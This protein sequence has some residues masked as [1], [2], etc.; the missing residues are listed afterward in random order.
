MK[1]VEAV[2]MLVNE[3]IDKLRQELVDEP[4]LSRAKEQIKGNLLLGL[5]STCNRMSRLAKMELFKDT[6]STPEETVARIDEITSEAVLH[7]ACDLFKTENFVTAAIGPF[8]E[9]QQ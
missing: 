6:L 7:I 1:N 9:Q 4:E 5:E 3:E 8:K 2:K